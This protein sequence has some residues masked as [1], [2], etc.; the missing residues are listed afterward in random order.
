MKQCGYCGRQYSDDS[1]GFC[2]DDGSALSVDP[3]ATVLATKGARNAPESV[4]PPEISPER[5]TP[6]KGPR[7]NWWYGGVLLVAALLGAALVV[8]Y[9]ETRS[10]DPVV[11]PTP[12]GTS[13]TPQPV[14]ESKSTDPVVTK[15]NPI[16]LTGEWRLTNTVTESTYRPY[17]NLKLDYRIVITQQGQAFTGNGEKVREAGQNLPPSRRTTIS[18]KGLVHADRVEATFTEKGSRRPTAGRFVWQLESDG[19]RLDGSFSSEAARSQGS[20]VAVKEK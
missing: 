17:L 9:N 20:S 12:S 14:G 5:P 1:L 7:R 4:D 11:S 2:L 8:F 16:N 3:E 6:A 13:S 10:S 19:S 15:D 18:L